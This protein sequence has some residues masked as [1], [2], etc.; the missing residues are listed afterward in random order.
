[1]LDRHILTTICNCIFS[2]IQKNP[3]RMHFYSWKSFI[4]EVS[5][6]H[7]WWIILCSLSDFELHKY[8]TYLYIKTTNSIN[9]FEHADVQCTSFILIKND[10][11][12][13]SDKR[14]IFSLI[15]LYINQLLNVGLYFFLRISV[16]LGLKE[17]QKITKLEIWQFSYRFLPPSV[18]SFSSSTG[19]WKYQNK[20]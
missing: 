2:V 8:T 12:I 14:I 13:L 7:V 10:H 5:H 15:F 1:M 17:K 4:H 6:F 19:F 20:L 18:V 9:D 11:L 3:H 16:L